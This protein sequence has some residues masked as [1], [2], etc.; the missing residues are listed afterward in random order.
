M[1]FKYKQSSQHWCMALYA[2]CALGANAY[3][4][5]AFHVYTP[6]PFRPGRGFGDLFR[7]HFFA[8]AGNCNNVKF[9]KLWSDKCAY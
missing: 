7:T 2:G 8:N 5:M 1:D 9:C 3:W 6:L 4:S